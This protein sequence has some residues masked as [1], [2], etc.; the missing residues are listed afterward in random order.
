MAAAPPGGAVPAD[1]A[2][3]AFSRQQ[4]L[5]DFD[6][7]LV[8]RQ[9]CFV[10]GSGGVG[11][12]IGMTLARMGVAHVTFVDMDTVATSNLNRQLLF[13]PD[14]VGMNKVDA[15][16]QSLERSHAFRTSAAALHCNAVT[17]WADIVAEAQEQHMTAIF[18]GCDHGGF[19]D[20]AL[21]ALA[22]ALDSPC[23]YTAAST[24]AY[25]YQVDSYGTAAGEPCLLCTNPPAHSISIDDFA[26][27]SG[28]GRASEDAAGA[29]TAEEALAVLKRVYQ[30]EHELLPGMVRRS[31]A[32]ASDGAATLP[33]TRGAV[34]RFRSAL[35]GEILAELTPARVLAHTSLAFIPADPKPDTSSVGSWAV[36]CCMGSMFAVNCWVQRLAGQDVPPMT[37][38]NIN[39]QRGSVWREQMGWD[40]FKFHPEPSDGCTLCGFKAPGMPA[41]EVAAMAAAEAAAAAEAEERDRAATLARG[42]AAAAALG[43]GLIGLLSVALARRGAQA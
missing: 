20:I 35:T 25:T 4:N 12:C 18:N 21:Q 39:A 13:T 22:R 19:F 16:K 7:E 36:V 3:A 15:C 30:S 32:A 29:I 28:A 2:T 10:V 24:Y 5:V 42:F 8:R 17:R 23:L 27:A 41:E 1:L 9:R 43:A 38:A 14:Q 37:I 31:I 34:L 6:D 33:R 40:S 26:A 11:S